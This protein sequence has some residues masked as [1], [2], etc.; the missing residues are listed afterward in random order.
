MSDQGQEGVANCEEAGAEIN[1]SEK[2]KI[3]FYKTTET[4]IVAVA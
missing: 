3:R 4:R 2:C 1:D